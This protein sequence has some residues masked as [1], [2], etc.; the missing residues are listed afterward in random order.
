MFISLSFGVFLFDW[1]GRGFSGLASRRPI[2]AQHQKSSWPGLTRPS[3][4]FSKSIKTWMPGTEAG[5]DELSQ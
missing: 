3:T 2:P 4:S 5:H 1:I